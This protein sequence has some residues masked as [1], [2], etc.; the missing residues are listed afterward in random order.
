MKDQRSGNADA[1]A[2]AAGK[3]VRIPAEISFVQT[4]LVNDPV[5]R[6]YRLEISSPGI[7]RPLRTPEHFERFAGE[8]VQ[9]VCQ[10]PVNGRS[11]WSGTLLGYRE[12]CVLVD[13]D[14]EEVALELANV[15]RANVKGIIDFNAK[16]DFGSDTV[17]EG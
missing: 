2:L 3:C 16:A 12:G 4:D 8:R 6:A 14:G 15:K 10:S 7:D 11:R 5:D 17:L 1:L 13:V 9:V